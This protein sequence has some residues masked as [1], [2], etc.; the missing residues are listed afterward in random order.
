MRSSEP[1]SNILTDL[2]SDSHA[3]DDHQRFLELVPIPAFIMS[4]GHLIIG[5]NSAARGFLDYETEDR[6][7]KNASDFVRFKGTVGWDGVAND[8]WVDCE[9][10]GRNLMPIS[11]EV[12]C[13]RISGGHRLVFINDD[14]TRRQTDTAFLASEKLRWRAQKNEVLERLAGGIAHDFNNILAVILLHTDILNLQ[15][16][17]DNPL[18]KRVNEIKAVS[19]DAAAIVRQ[20]LA[21]AQ[22]QALNPSPVVLNNAIRDSAV[23]INALVGSKISLELSLDPDLG[24]CFVDQNQL[25][26]AL[27]YL[28]VNA[29]DAIPNGGTL[30]IETANVVLDRANTHKAQAGGPFIQISV[31]DS[32]MG[33]DSKIEDHIFEP[34]FSTKG[35][36]KGA[37]LGLATVYGIVKQSGGFIWVETKLGSGTTFRIQ[38]PRV[39]QP[40]LN[41]AKTKATKTA[42]SGH[43]T[44]LLVEDEASVRRV[45]A[46][47]LRHTGYKVV[48]AGGGEEAIG[49]A[50]LVREPI[51]LLLTDF[52]MPNMNGSETA[53]RIKEIHPKTSVLY[54]SGNLSD[55][56]A[57]QPDVAEKAHFLGKPFSSSELTHKIREILGS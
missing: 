2:F 18:L 41:A 48:E 9:I 47:I 55:I 1:N 33:M 44:I 35:S 6:T 8:C 14:S 5:V 24:V 17:E 23:S 50:R 37:G 13:R 39:D 4:A 19:N 21:F 32:G 31:T 7:G 57:H 27:M 56:E 30:K 46:E 43:E 15:L 25:V 22:K 45:A 53:K 54:M 42:V 11:A 52:S 26:Q 40:Q 12:F 3:V 28:A 51:H 20:L 38:F 49:I 10:L 36:D 16:S 34:F 29:R